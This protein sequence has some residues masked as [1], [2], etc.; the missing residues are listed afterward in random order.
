M[1][2]ILGGISLEKEPGMQLSEIKR[3][4]EMRGVGKDQVGKETTIDRLKKRWLSK[5]LI[6]L[7]VLHIH[8]NALT[9]CSATKVIY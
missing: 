6:Y 7:R 9:H 5:T 8:L 2:Q 1:I 3:R 4:G